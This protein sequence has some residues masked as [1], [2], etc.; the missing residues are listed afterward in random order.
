MRLCSARLAWRLIGLTA[1]ACPPAFLLSACVIERPG[2]FYDVRFQSPPP[3][4]VCVEFARDVAA[5]TGLQTSGKSFQIPRRPDSCDTWVAD[6][7]DPQQRPHLGVGI[8]TD[9][10]RNL[11]LVDVWERG[12]RK[13]WHSAQ[14]KQLGETLADLIHQRFPDAQMTPGKRAQG[15]FA[16]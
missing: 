8:M 15:P 9:P 3:N 13:P 6:T 2:V 5:R 10:T 16:P 12:H 7:L 14:A 1:S 11:L 4:T